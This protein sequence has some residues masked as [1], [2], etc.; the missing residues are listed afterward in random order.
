MISLAFDPILFMNLVLCIIILVLGIICTKRSGEF[1]PIY[2]GAAFGLFGVSHAATLLGLKDYLT[3]PLILVRLC[4]YLL[5]VWALI[6]FL[7]N[8]LVA[9]EAQQAWV[10]YFNDDGSDQEKG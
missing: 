4:A 2:I 10:D 8:T 1:L 5:V 9:K 7:K 6:L 3:I